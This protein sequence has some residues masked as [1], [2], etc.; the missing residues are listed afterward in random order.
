MPRVS[1]LPQLPLGALLGGETIPVV[2][3][4][5]TVKSS[6][7]DI[8]HSPMFPNTNTY[9]IE[10][11]SYEENGFTSIAEIKF[12]QNG[13]EIPSTNI[14]DIQFSGTAPLSLT[15]ALGN[16][17]DGNPAT[18]V[19][20]QYD[21]NT[22]D[23]FIT[24]TFNS[25]NFR[26]DEVRVTAPDSGSGVN[27]TEVPAYIVV[28]A[29]G[30]GANLQYSF[31]DYDDSSSIWETPWAYS[32]ERTV[33][34]PTL[35]VNAF[36]PQL[37]V[38]SVDTQFENSVYVESESCTSVLLRIP[39]VY[40]EVQDTTGNI[41]GAVD[42]NGLPVKL[43]TSTVE[44]EALTHRENAALLTA[45][46]ILDQASF[47]QFNGNYSANTF[48]LRN[49]SG[50]DTTI[51]VIPGN[52]FTNSKLSP[53]SSRKTIINTS[54]TY[55]MTLDVSA[56]GTVIGSSALTVPPLGIVHFIEYIDDEIA[57]WQ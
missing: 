2:Q 35:L 45:G 56:F 39:N 26:V 55:N 50:A 31:A 47:Y 9:E 3:D 5:Q 28:R 46:Q 24:V 38:Y 44:I 36:A 16:V 43:G 52:Q 42:A 19:R 34:A 53:L 13:V 7:Y 32:E 33:L 22:W 57:I 30:T 15:G 4:G 12:Y 37:Q 11:L 6:I 51:T 48:Y 1:Q 18:Y 23:T 49:L 10:T 29:A 25:S 20:F 40:A 21:V 54:A 41:F 27:L 17:I 8:R 14:V